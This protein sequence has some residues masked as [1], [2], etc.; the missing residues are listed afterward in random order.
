MY[1]Y[2]NGTRYLTLKQQLLSGFYSSEMFE[3]LCQNLGSCSGLAEGRDY[4]E[5]MDYFI[6][7]SDY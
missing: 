2:G 3:G 7:H 5:F 6:N 4:N 1:W